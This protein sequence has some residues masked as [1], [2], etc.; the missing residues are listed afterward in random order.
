MGGASVDAFAFVTA[1]DEAGARQE[2]PGFHP[3]RRKLR[4]ELAESGGARIV[5]EVPAGAL[6][7]TNPGFARGS[8]VGTVAV[9]RV[10]G[11]PATVTDGPRNTD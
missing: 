11:R 8:F 5:V 6:E 1:L 10:A 4:D 9:A 2:W 3:R 7:K